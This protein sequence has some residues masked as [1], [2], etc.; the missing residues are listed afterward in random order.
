DLI[1][2][3][4]P[5]EGKPYLDDT[6]YPLVQKWVE[7]LQ[8]AGINITFSSVFRTTQDQ[9]KLRNNPTPKYPIAKKSL[10]ECGFAIDVSDIWWK[11]LPPEK[12]KIIIRAAY[13]VGLM[14]GITFKT[15]ADPVHFYK[16]VPG[17]KENRQIYIDLAQSQFRHFVAFALFQAMRVLAASLQF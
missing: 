9:K 17:G 3:N 10:H 14:W 1:R 15:R 4:L 6:F 12:R 8:L 11:S 2:V 7:K 5:G 13:E 16:E